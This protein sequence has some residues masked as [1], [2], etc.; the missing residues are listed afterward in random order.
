MR[1]LS[2]RWRCGALLAAWAVALMI[3]VAGCPQG[4]APPAGNPPAVQP[5]A[6]GVDDGAGDQ[7]G[8][9]PDAGDEDP[10]SGD[11][12]SSDNETQ[13]QGDDAG[14]SQP[15]DGDQPDGDK[16][17]DDSP[18][19]DDPPGETEIRTA[20]TFD[21]S[22]LTGAYLMA[23]HG[24]DG[25]NDTCDMPDN[26]HVYIASSDDGVHWT[27]PDDWQPYQASVPD[28]VERGDTIYI[29]S[30]N[31]VVL[32]DKTTGEVSE[33]IAV[34]LEAEELPAGFVDPSPTLDDEGRIVL[35]CIAGS[36]TGGIGT[37][38]GGETTCTIHVYSATETD[39]RDGIHF[40]LDEGTRADVELDTS[41]SFKTATDP[42]I[43]YD[44]TQYVLYVSQG[45]SMTVWTSAELRGNYTLVDTLPDGLLNLGTGGVGSGVRDETT[46]MIWTFAH[47]TEDG[48]F[49][50]RR[51]V[52]ADFSTQLAEDDFSVIIQ[53]TD[54]GMSAEQGNVA[55]PGIWKR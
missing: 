23:F 43:F 4:G 8:D 13:D 51:A 24:C 10:A 9:T 39:A 33:P 54:L 14:G 55:S 17:D 3:I 25:G 47:V 12:A 48:V 1:V 41:T 7:A 2:N 31:E 26:H 34:D 35:F 32:I 53:G 27:V 5:P 30:P 46:G 50:I 52:H 49:L 19:N 37:C 22:A 6:G 36:L 45:A 44:G 11:D 20:F 29:Y 21:A 15:D 18:P 40:T 28:L 38:T 42:D 16:P